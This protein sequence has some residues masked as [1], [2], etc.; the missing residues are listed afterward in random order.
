MTTDAHDQE[1]RIA[2]L[3]QQVALLCRALGIDNDDPTQVVP[4]EVIELVRQ[5]HQVQAMHK[6]RQLTGAGLVS[7]KE[8]VDA[9]AATLGIPTASA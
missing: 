8:L 9:A 5:D 2:R 1:D 3:E 7:A 4:D 6:M